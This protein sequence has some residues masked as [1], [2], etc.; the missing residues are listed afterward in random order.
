MV[1]MPSVHDKKR[2]Q[3]VTGQLPDIMADPVYSVFVVRLCGCACIVSDVLHHRRWLWQGAA[4]DWHASREW[5]SDG[6]SVAID[7]IER[8]FGGASVWATDTTRHAPR[9]L[10]PAQSS[11]MLFA[12]VINENLMSGQAYQPHAQRAVQAVSMSTQHITAL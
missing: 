10:C 3:H 9:S 6:G 8:E 2:C 1:M 4:R 12:V 7:T 11:C 5:V